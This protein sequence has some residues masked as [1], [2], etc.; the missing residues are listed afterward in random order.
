MAPMIIM[1][2]KFSEF[3][4]IF[5]TIMVLITTI[6]LAN[7]ILS[8][9]QTPTKPTATWDAIGNKIDYASPNAS[10][11]VKA[12]IAGATT[13]TTITTAPTIDSKLKFSW[14]SLPVAANTKAVTFSVTSLKPL[15][16]LSPTSVG[17]PVSS[18]GVLT[19]YEGVDFSDMIAT[20]YDVDIEPNKAGYV[21]TAIPPAAM[22]STGR[23]DIDPIF[24]T[25]SVGIVN[26]TGYEDCGSLWAQSIGGWG[27]QRIANFC[28]GA[29]SFF[30]NYS[31]N[32]TTG[33]TLFL[34]DCEIVFRF[35]GGTSYVGINN[36]GNLTV[37]RSNITTNTTGSNFGQFV[38]GAGIQYVNRYANTTFRDSFLTGFFGAQISSAIIDFKNTTLDTNFA[39]ALSFERTIGNWTMAN[40]TL[41]GL[42]N[43]II[44][45]KNA[46]ITGFRNIGS[47]SSIS[48]NAADNFTCIDCN[49]TS[50]LSTD[51]D[52]GASKNVIMLNTTYKLSGETATTGNLERKWYLLIYVNSTTGYP[53]EGAAVSSFSNMTYPIGVTNSTG[54]LYGTVQD[55]KRYGATRINTSNITATYGSAAGNVSYKG[56]LE[57]NTYNKNITLN[58]ENITYWI[59]KQLLGIMDL[60]NGVLLAINIS[61]NRTMFYINMIDDT[62]H[63][64]YSLY[65]G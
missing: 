62:N 60:S 34:K 8:Q 21:V 58:M 17:V 64:T 12:E 13:S 19:L 28:T 55:Y 31:F 23:L 22:L 56:W 49:L 46:T 16:Y 51:I 26:I 44:M 36:Y 11:S 63:G 3:D 61:D 5:L 65:R 32:I 42:G 4:G 43:L 38:S 40:I 29:C 48:L 18:N 25:Q 7:S 39:R 53:I 59:R 9:G 30:S 45:S 14:N 50:A 27:T 24:F 20:G 52:I 15:H 1:G 35:V 41:V 33:S 47:Q 6:G 54:Y 10:L 37:I 2:W 57:N